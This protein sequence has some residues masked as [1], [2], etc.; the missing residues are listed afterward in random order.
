MFSG[1]Y[2]GDSA[3]NTTSMN[4]KRFLTYPTLESLLMTLLMTCE[5]VGKNPTY[6]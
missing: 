5:G 2:L 1:I 6:R 3:K 4:L